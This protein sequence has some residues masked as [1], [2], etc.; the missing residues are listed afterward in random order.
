LRVKATEESAYLSTVRLGEE[1]MREKTCIPPDGGFV[2]EKSAQR[3]R[4]DRQG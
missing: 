2:F 1:D 4:G 3:V